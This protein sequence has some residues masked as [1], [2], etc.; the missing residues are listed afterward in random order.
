VIVANNQAERDHHDGPGA[1]GQVKKVIGCD[2]LAERRRCPEGDLVAQRDERE[3]A[4]LP[5]QI[6]SALDSDIVYHEYGHG[7][8][9]RMIGHMSGPIAGAIGEGNSDGIALLINGDD[10]IGEYGTSSPCGFRRAPYA[11]Y[12]NTYGDFGLPCNLHS[13]QRRH[14]KSTTTARSTRPSCGE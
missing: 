10:C 11:G 13:L 1:S 9:W 14:L 8:S 3:L 5:L 7:L 2:D 12:P 4:V 6:D